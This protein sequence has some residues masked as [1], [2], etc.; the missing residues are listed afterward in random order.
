MV[1]N[2]CVVCPPFVPS[3]NPTGTYKRLFRVPSGWAKDSQIRLRFEGVDSAYHVFVNGIEVGYSQG[4]RNPAEFDVTSLVSDDENE[5]FVRVY[6]WSDGSYI[7]DQDQWWLSGIFRDVYLL[8][9]PK[10]RIEDFGV[11]AGL[12]SEYRHGRFS[13]IVKLA[14]QDDIEIQAQISRRGEVITAKK[15]QIRSNGIETKISLNISTPDKW[16]AETPNLYDLE[17][18]LQSGGDVMQTIRQRI[19]FREVELKSGLITVNGVPLLFKGVNRHDHHPLHGRA[20][21][22]EFMRNDLLL[23]KQHNVNAL[24]T[25]HYPNHPLLYDLCDELGLWVIDEADLECHGFDAA[26]VQSLNLPSSTRYEE[27]QKIVSKSASEFTSDNPAWETAYLDR[28]EQLVQRDKNHTS[29]IIWSLGN[30]AFYGRNHKAMYEYAKKADPTRLVHYEGDR[31]AKSA[32]MY[33]YMYPSVDALVQLAKTE[34]VKPDGTYDKPIV[35]CEY[36]H[37]MGNGP[38]WLTEYVDA[39]RTHDRLQGGFIWEWANHGL[40]KNDS[41]GQYYAY[42]G[43]FGDVPNDSTF[44][45]DGLLFSNHTPTPGLIELKKVYAPVRGWLDEDGRDVIIENEYQFIDLAHLAIDYKIETFGDEE[46]TLIA[47]GVVELS[48]ITAGSRTTVGVPDFPLPDYLTGHVFMTISFRNKEAT[49]WSEAGFEVAWLQ[50]PLGSNKSKDT[51]SPQ[52]LR[53]SATSFGVETTQASYIISTPDM[54]I[55]FDRSTGYPTQWLVNNRNLLQQ[56]KLNKETTTPLLLPSFWRAPTDNDKASDANDWKSYGLDALTTQLRSLTITPSSTDSDAFSIISTTYVAPPILAWGFHVTTT[57][58]IFSAANALR[59]KYHI[60]PSGP[61]PRTLCHIGLQLRLAKD[62]AHAK[63][64]GLGPGESYAD[65][66]KAQRAGIWKADVD[67]LFTN[68]EVPQENGNRM[69]TRWLRVTDGR[70]EGGIKVTLVD[71]DSKQGD[72]RKVK[73]FQ[74]QL[75][76]YDAKTLEEAKHPC[77]LAGKEEEGMLLRLDVAHAGVGTGA[78]GPRISEECEVKC[79]EREFEFLLEPLI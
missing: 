76:K 58:S 70:G 57:Y 2:R 23:M 4:S 20:V 74:W 43:D 60:T 41:S 19:G 47:A 68:Y 72:E 32:D 8:A 62:L 78:C 1:P 35:L 56:P 49:S 55:R 9:F 6:Q 48:D 67:E 77:D 50:V 24:R 39:F 15:R 21:P 7:E 71:D 28:M 75:S 12:D 25:S 63:W 64:F 51:P 69:D 45:M 30:E 5:L 59:I 16:T 40:L 3:E 37:A 26:I 10:S 29:V 33:S 11:M 22:Y 18:K 73:M 14:L 42:G 53:R 38:G 27:R 31:E 54:T 34:G 79:E 17:L 52:S 44:V 65:T 36:A 66:R 46:S 61:A 13:I